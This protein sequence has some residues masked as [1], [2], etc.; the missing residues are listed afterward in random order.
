VLVSY[1]IGTYYI[2]GNYFIGGGKVPDVSIRSDDTVDVRRDIH[3][4]PL[5][6]IQMLL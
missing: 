2:I 3:D 4:S 6:R 5:G 1:D